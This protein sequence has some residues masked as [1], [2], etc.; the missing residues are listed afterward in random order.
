M[1]RRIDV[2]GLAGSALVLIALVLYVFRQAEGHVWR[3]W[4][5]STALWVI[6]CTLLAAWPLL[7]FFLGAGEQKPKAKAEKAGSFGR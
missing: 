2:V 3:D 6:G 5:L 7:R 1:V 4:V